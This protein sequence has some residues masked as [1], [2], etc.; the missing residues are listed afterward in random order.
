MLRA[1]SALLG[2]LLGLVAARVADALPRRLGIT[3]LVTGRRRSI[4]NLLLVILSTACWLGIAHVLADQHE[5]SV[6]RATVL[7]VTNG[8]TATCVLAGAAID[9][10]HMILPNELTVAPALLCLGTAPFRPVGV[11]SAFG[12]ALLG[13][14]LAYLPLLLFRRVRGHG[15]AGLG[16]AK[17]AALAGAWLGALG[18]PFVLFFGALQVTIAAGL[19]RVLGVSYP[20]PPSVIAELD[21]LRTRAS[22]GDTEAKRELD[23][24]PMAAEA[25]D[26]VLQMRLP[27]G[28]FLALACIEVLFLREWLV[29]NVIGWLM[30]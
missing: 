14:A 2:L 23:D 4:R 8:I 24:D 15:G 5:L 1:G 6:G 21:E 30:R 10:E 9:L 28:P 11:A 26:G 27:L 12:G 17:L 16:D 18:V 20:V 25:T 29:T 3:H 19:M 22:S 7:L 13:L